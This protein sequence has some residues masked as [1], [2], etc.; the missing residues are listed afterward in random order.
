M[1]LLESDD[2]VKALKGEKRPINTR[3]DRAR[4]LAALTAPDYVICL[5]KQ[6]SNE[7]YDQLVLEIKP[8][9][10]ATTKN[11]PGRSHKKRQADMLSISVVDVIEHIDHKSTSRIATLLEE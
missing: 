10:I 5:P 8:A 7:Q 4:I 2:A 9:I 6:A 3:L 1:V 11:D